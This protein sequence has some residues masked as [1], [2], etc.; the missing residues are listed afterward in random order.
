MKLALRLPI[1]G[2]VVPVCKNDFL[3]GLAG[4][5]LKM[6]ILGKM[7]T[8]QQIRIYFIVEQFMQ[9]P[10]AICLTFIDHA[11]IIKLHRC[12]GNHTI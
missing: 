1:I 5:C 6:T 12:S 8:V 9:A 3:A 7:D 4:Y 10:Q 2:Y 11:C